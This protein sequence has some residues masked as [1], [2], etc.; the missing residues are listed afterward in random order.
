MRKYPIGIQDFRDLR[1]GGYTYVDKTNYLHTLATT[2]KY[3]FL[4][5]PRRFGK[6]LLLSTFKELFSGSRELFEGLWIYDNWDWQK[7]HPVIRISFSD[8]GVNT[9]G[10]VPAICKTLAETALK[11]GFSL[12]SGVYDQQFKELI[13]KAAVKNKVVILIDEYD[14]PITDNLDNLALAEENRVISKNFYSILK[15]ASPFIEFLLITGVSEF[16]KVSI[17]SD[18]NHLQ[19]ITLHREMNNLIGITQQ[20][21]DIIFNQEL[22]ELPLFFKWDKTR[23]TREIKERY[24]GYNWGG[25]DTV[26]NPFSLLSFFKQKE[27]KNYW[28]ET[29]TPTFLME[30]IKKRGDFDFEEVITAEEGLNDFN[31]QKLSPVTLLFQTGYL[32][33]KSIDTVRRKYTLGYPNKEVRES[34]LAYLIGAYRDGFAYESRPMII[35]L[36]DALESNDIEAVVKVINT[37]FASIPYDL[38]RDATELHYHALVHL[39]FSMLGAY[40]K[41]EVH[42]ANGRCDA[43]VETQDAIYAIE[44][45]LDLSARAA[46]TQIIDRGYLEPYAL[47]GKKRRAVGLNFSSGAKK[48]EGWLMQEIIS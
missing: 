25:T 39:L 37:A 15:D 2:G 23:L 16:S 28:F 14:K 24:N 33:I 22:E 10:L 12:D 40:L 32:T 7:K 20:E 31:I 48:V 43:L 1:E 18:L 27:F 21:M 42:S 41:S 8:I 5:R 46:L 17:F 44:F 26:Y 36:E 9:M 3:Y 4:S 19:D 47:T 6:S 45:K 29:G 35:N 34:M 11:L 13:H 38:W 30:Q